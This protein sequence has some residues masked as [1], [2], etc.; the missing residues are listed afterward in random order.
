MTQVLTAPPSHT[1][2]NRDGFIRGHVKRV[3]ARELASVE[4]QIAL[5]ME[6]RQNLIDWLKRNTPQPP[7]G[8]RRVAGKDPAAWTSASAREGPA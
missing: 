2:I 3:A 6:Q 1:R 7:E 4:S 8:P 5:L